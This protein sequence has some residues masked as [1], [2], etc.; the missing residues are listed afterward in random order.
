MI[1]TSFRE[2]SLGALD[3]WVSTRA[4][5]QDLWSL[6]INLNADNLA[7]GSTVTLNTA[8]NDG[9]PTLSWDGQELLFYSNR[10]GGLGGTDL[11]VT[12][13]E[14]ADKQRTLMAGRNWGQ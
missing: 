14:K 9:A 12:R 1:I 10:G 7:K 11:Y 2:T 3:M 13:R 6:P 8:A 5:T 4:S